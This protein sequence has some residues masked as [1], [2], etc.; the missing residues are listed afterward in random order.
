MSPSGIAARLQ[1]VLVRYH[2]PSWVG[3]ATVALLAVIGVQ[4]KFAHGIVVAAI[5]YW[6]WGAVRGQLSR[7]GWLTLETAGVL[8]FGAVMLVAL[9]LDGEQARLV[10][11]AGWLAHAG[12]DVAHHR[13]DMIVPRWYAEFCGVLDVLLAAVVLTLPTS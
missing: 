11:A 10:L 7:P 3:A 2:W 4:T 5:V 9:A 1:P 6:V 12:W 13:A 8:A